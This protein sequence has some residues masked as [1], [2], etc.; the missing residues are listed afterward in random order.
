VIKNRIKE[1]KKD[2]VAHILSNKMRIKLFNRIPRKEKC[3]LGVDK[4]V[5]MKKKRKREMW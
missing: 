3:Y 1:L 4:K 2:Q 5:K